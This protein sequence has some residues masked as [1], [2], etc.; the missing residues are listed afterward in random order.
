MRIWTLLFLN[1]TMSAFALPFLDSSEWQ[2]MSETFWPLL[3]IMVSS[4]LTS[5]LT[6]VM[7]TRAL[8]RGS[9]S[10][11]NSLSAISVVLGIPIALVGNFLLPGAFGE[12]A[13]EIFVWIVKGFGIILVIIGVIAL[14]AADVRALVLI[15]VKSQTGDI[16]PVL[17]NIKGV[18]K[19]SA[20][21]GDYDYLICVKS[22]SLGKTRSNILN[23]LNAI[24]EIKY[25]ETMVVLQDFR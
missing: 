19:A 16:L 10:V 8:G 17:F 11:V 14:Q 22:R 13:T 9:M 20:I 6:L 4:S 3:V 2:I 24:P 7:Y 15:K 5:F 21:A 12:L 25:H 23:K 1:L 18:E